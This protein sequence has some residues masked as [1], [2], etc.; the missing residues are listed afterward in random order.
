MMGQNSGSQN[1]L[2]YSFY[3][4][5]H[6]PCSHLLRGIDAFLDLTDLR[7]YLGRFYSHTG[8]H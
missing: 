7:A 4:E 8:R 3:L 2:F 1:R 5:D 6:V